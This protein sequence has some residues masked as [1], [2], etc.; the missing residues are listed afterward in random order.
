M[1]TSPLARHLVSLGD[2]AEASSVLAPQGAMHSAARLKTAEL[3]GFERGRQAAETG[4][5]Q[6]LL[7]LKQQHAD[8]QESAR[9]RWSH[10][11]ADRLAGDLAASIVTIKRE[12]SDT[13]AH[14]ILP[15]VARRLQ[16][17]A[18][19]ELSRAALELVNES[20]PLAVDISGPLEMTSILARQ[21][22][23]LSTVVRIVP[24]DQAELRVR[25]DSSVLQTRLKE[26]TSLIQE[27]MQ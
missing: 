7:A 14:G 18:V 27:A 24:G 10:S 5:E 11:V 23:Q 25:V 6:R 2:A 21:M 3:A 16:D 15:L 4:V 13:I 26:W 20:V 1:Q 22:E 12:L 17:D 8:E 9:L 19:E